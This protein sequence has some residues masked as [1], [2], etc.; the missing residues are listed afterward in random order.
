MLTQEQ[1][2][3]YV[4]D[5]FLAFYEPVLPREDVATTCERIDELFDHW[6]SLPRRLAQGLSDDGGPPLIA[7]LQSV[8]AMDRTIA[9][10]ALVKI[11]RRYA[12]DILDVRH[13]W[14]H[15]DTAIYKLPGAGSVDWHQDRAES[16]SGL[17]SNSV[18]FWIPLNDHAGDSGSLVFVPG[19]HKNGVVEHHRTADNAY[20]VR[21]KADTPDRS[22][23]VGVPL[24]IGCFSMHSPLTLH[25]SDPNRG[26][27]I[28]K[29]LVLQF[30][31]N[32]WSAARQ[33]GRPLVRV[34]CW[35]ASRN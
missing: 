21:K 32:P 5:G 23:T 13:P 3:R 6:D 34:R 2:T 24:S 15:Y 27:V 8:M 29:A 18:H 10:G 16:R 14:C 30:G 35:L 17:L 12:A 28:R 31:A 9:D 11:C 33:L 4:R 22:T 7:Q 26:D 1:A 20:V 19:S 25:S